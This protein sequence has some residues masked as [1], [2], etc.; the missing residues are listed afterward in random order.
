MAMMLCCVMS[1]VT[2]LTDLDTSQKDATLFYSL[3]SSLHHL[4]LAGISVLF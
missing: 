3:V 4:D 1:Q 2:S